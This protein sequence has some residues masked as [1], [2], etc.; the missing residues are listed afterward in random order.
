MLSLLEGVLA[1]H[2][3]WSFITQRSDASDT[4]LGRT[5]KETLNFDRALR[6]VHEFAPGARLSLQALLDDA[7]C[8]SHWLE[9]ELTVALGKVTQLLEDDPQAWA[10]AA[11]EGPFHKPA[12]GDLATVENLALAGHPSS[13][14]GRAGGP[15]IVRAAERFLLLLDVLR[16]RY[17]EVPQEH[18]RRDYFHRVQLQACVRF[19]EALDAEQ[20]RLAGRLFGQ[21]PR[22]AVER[23]P[24]V[25]LLAGLV[26]L[27]NTAGHLAAMLSQLRLDNFYRR[28]LV[29][30]PGG[31]APPCGLLLSS[32]QDRLQHIHLGTLATLA[33]AVAT[34]LVASLSEYTQAASADT[35]PMDLDEVRPAPQ[36]GPVQRMCA[37]LGAAPL[38]L[39]LSPADR[40]AIFRALCE[41]LDLHLLVRLLARST[42]PSSS[43]R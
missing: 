36:L 8:R 34:L 19:I 32:L 18:V 16:S 29:A 17:E 10:S 40:E 1:E 24:P 23:P 28:L 42:C 30:D 26:L 5:I 22:G 39:I 35:L 20:T 4:Y 41:A 11:P 43:G 12:A 13:L 21:L 31:T 37:A 33:G 3:R 7:A 9:S 27:A 14:A 2:W 6:L 25:D 38:F 15:P